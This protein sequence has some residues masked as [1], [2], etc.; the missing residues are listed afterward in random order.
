MIGWLTIYFSKTYEQIVIG[1]I[2]SG[3]AM[4]LASVPATVYSAE[5]T[6]PKLRST[7]LTWTSISIACGV[8]I[9][10]IFGYIYPVIYNYEVTFSKT[11]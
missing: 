11:L 1:R 2:L 9:V 8:L 5:V 10:Y 6:S 7:T 3:I 4:G